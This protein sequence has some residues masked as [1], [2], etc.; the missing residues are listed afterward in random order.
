MTAGASPRSV[1][2][3][4]A[5]LADIPQFASRNVITTTWAMTCPLV[6]SISVSDTGCSRH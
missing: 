4:L 3:D 6:R 1:A 2:A 5:I